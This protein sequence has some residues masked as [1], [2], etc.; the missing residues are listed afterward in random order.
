MYVLDGD[1]WLMGILNVIFDSFFDG[2]EYVLFE[3]VVDW[4]RVMVDLG[5]VMIDIGGELI[6]L[7]AEF[8]EMVEELWWVILVIEV[9]V[10]EVQVL[11]SIDMMKVDVVR[12]VVEVGVFVVNDV[13]GLEVD[14]EMVMMCVE[15]DVV[16]VCM[17]MWGIFE[18]M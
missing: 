10:V 3:V 7:G 8:V 16:I 17:Y 11:V 4:V 13:L 5:V 14:P 12:V 9:V 2:G 15:L 18:T 1:L 6:W